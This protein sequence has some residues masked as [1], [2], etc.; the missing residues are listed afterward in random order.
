MTEDYKEPDYD[1]GDRIDGAHERLREEKKMTHKLEFSAA[2]F[3]SLIAFTMGKPYEIEVKIAEHIARKTNKKL[4]ELLKRHGKVVYAKIGRT[5]FWTEAPPTTL[6]TTD[7]RATL[8]NI[9]R[10]YDEP[11]KHNIVI[12]SSVETLAIKDNMFHC[13]ECKQKFKPTAWEEA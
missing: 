12:S 3:Q 9:E 5:D 6:T 8:I 4:E 11:C 10:F 7:L 2:F 13:T 1:L